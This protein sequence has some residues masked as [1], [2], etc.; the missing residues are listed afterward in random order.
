MLSTAS[1]ILTVGTLEAL[2]LSVAAFT[3]SSV[4]SVSSAIP[5]PSALDVLGVTEP[6]LV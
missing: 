2:S 4:A 3:T 1:P 5:N 6:L